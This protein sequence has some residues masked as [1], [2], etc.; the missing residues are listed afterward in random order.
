MF[1][2][3]KKICLLSKVP[4]QPSSFKCL[5]LLLTGS[6]FALEEIKRMSRVD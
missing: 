6:C 4:V 5:A 1:Y 2:I 3:I